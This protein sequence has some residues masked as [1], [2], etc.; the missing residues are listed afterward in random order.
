MDELNPMPWR[1]RDATA[2]TP[3]VHVLDAGGR[4]V[5]TVGGLPQPDGGRRFEPVM[6][7]CRRRARL[8]AGCV[9]ACADIPLEALE[10]GALSEG[11]RALKLLME[12][13]LRVGFVND[14]GGRILPEDWAELRDLSERARSALQKL[15]PRPDWASVP[16]PE[17][18][19][20]GPVM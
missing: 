19:D 16:T 20:G 14:A 18:P 4:I 15:T 12:K 6:A 10:T 13:S 7:A 17:E 9:N 1:A 8:I 3:A 5:A 2:S 11:L